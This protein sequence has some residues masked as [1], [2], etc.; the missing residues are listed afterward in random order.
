MFQTVN[1][2]VQDLPQGILVVEVH[3]QLQEFVLKCVE[4]GL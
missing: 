1:K 3:H 4:T 2:I